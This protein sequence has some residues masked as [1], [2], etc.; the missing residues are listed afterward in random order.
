MPGVKPEKQKHS[1][2]ISPSQDSPMDCPVTVPLDPNQ[3]L[4]VTYVPHSRVEDFLR[5]NSDTV[6]AIIEYGRP[7]PVIVDPKL[8]AVSVNMEQLVEPPLSEIWTS[9][10][11]ISTHTVNGVH[12]AFNEE[13]VF[14]SIQGDELKGTGLEEGVYSVYSRVF[15]TLSLLGYPHLFRIWNYFSEINAEQKGLERYKQFC[16]GRHRAFS[17][18]YGE[19]QSVLPAAS[20]VGTPSGP[21]QLYFLAGKPKATHIE[22]PRQ[23]SAYDYPR[24]Y[25][26][27][28]PSFARATCISMPSWS[29]LFIAGTAS[30]V[31][32]ATQHTDDCLK[33]T[34]ETLSNLES[35]REQVKKGHRRVRSSDPSL[36]LLKVYVRHNQHMEFVR[37]TIQESFDQH[38]PTLY[39]SGEM[40][41]R[42]LLV[43]IE[44][45]YTLQH[46]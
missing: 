37:H 1:L 2:V 45:L 16:I 9:P 5:T 15:D 33:Q 26:P 31:G 17:E 24:M 6:L 19:F 3:E 29:Y 8:L 7:Q 28:S 36:S 41:R 12:V 10:F 32:H 20:A 27:K 22:N 21:F 4:R 34:K 38:I 46:S 14:G 13:V 44:A 40:C 39:L 25:G 35:L 42:N 18:H 23:I 30:I 11:P 43:E